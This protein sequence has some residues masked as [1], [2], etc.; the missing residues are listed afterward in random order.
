[1]NSLSLL[2][3][4]IH[5]WRR[6]SKQWC[7]ILKWNNLYADIWYLIDMNVFEKDDRLAIYLLVDSQTIEC[8]F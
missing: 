1:M 5:W 8:A 6:Y 4:S 3:D 7:P 2:Q